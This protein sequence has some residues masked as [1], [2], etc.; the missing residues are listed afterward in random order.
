MGPLPV[1]GYYST[2]RGEIAPV[3]LPFI[4]PFI[5]VMTPFITGGSPPCRGL[6]FI[7]GS[8]FF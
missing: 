8:F 3:N 5:G 1:W 7:F 2:Y 6:R 4:R